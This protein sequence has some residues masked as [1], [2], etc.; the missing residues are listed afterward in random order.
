MAQK[1]TSDPYLV[2]AI[3]AEGALVHVDSVPNGL[4]C[5][6]ICPYCKDNLIAKNGGEI[7]AHSFAHCSGADCVGAA[8]S[9]LHLLAKEVLCEEIAVALP[10][11]SDCT[12]NGLLR[13]ERVE[14]EEYYPELKLRPDCVGYY[15]D[16]QIWIEFKRT[17]AVDVN[18]EGKIISA[19][20]DC[21][22]I[23]LNKCKQDIEEVRKFITES[24]ENRKWIYNSALGLCESKRRER[25]DGYQRYNDS[26]IEY[27]IERHYAVEDGK[28]L[29]N[30]YDDDFDAFNHTYTCPSCGKEVF[31][32]VD[33]SGR[34]SFSHKEDNYCDDAL[35]LKKSATLMLRQVFDNTDQFYIS[36]PQ[37][38]SCKLAKTCRLVNESCVKVEQHR[39]DIKKHGFIVC[40]T[41][42]L[43]NEAT[44]RSDIVFCKENTMKDAISVAI[45]HPALP[46]E[47]E[48]L[49]A[50]QLRISISSEYDID[51]LKQG[52]EDYDNISYVGFKDIADTCVEPNETSR[53]LVKYTF[54]NTGKF[55][56]N[57]VQCNGVFTKSKYRNV[58]KEVIFV[59]STGNH[60]E[61]RNFL[62]SKFR[63][64]GVTQQ[65]YCYLCYF[66][67]KNTS[68][69]GNEYIC[70][71]YKTRGTPRNP[72]D[73]KPVNCPCFSIDRNVENHIAEVSDQMEIVEL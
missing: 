13:L 21:I 25:S 44:L 17:H 48:D 62:L 70:T 7:N 32:K 12:P 8:E 47:D 26:Y 64:S 22:E 61:M 65:C 42:Y 41:D 5:N 71:R 55:F 35:Y 59:R 39:F 31:V 24:F 50:R 19:H 15:G 6:C 20:I 60:D 2:Y 53:E 34:Y 30:V 14:K 54:Y 29:I 57:I 4:G 51:Q 67:K 10:I 68:M 18:K 38:H 52:I 1:K 36:V 3:N 49:N 16:K 66:L 23:D 45:T 69:W 43:F 56:P 46:I 72:L 63:K 33:D 27:R 58:I 40:K 11:R 37:R 73:V 28:R 9:V